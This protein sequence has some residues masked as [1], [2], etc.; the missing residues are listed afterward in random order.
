[1]TE[2]RA[3]S[4]SLVGY[5]EMICGDVEDREFASRPGGVNHPA[6]IL[7]HL[8]LTA[9]YTASIAGGKG[10]CPASWNSL[11][12]QKKPLSENRSEYPS[13]DELLKTLRAATENALN[14]VEKLSADK[15]DRPHEQGW[16]EKELPTMRDMLCFLLVGHAGIHVGQ[17][18][19]WRRM[20]GRA[21]L[22]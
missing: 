14:A 8:G 21:P 9:D 22:F 11:F 18:S 12:D 7:G 4:L 3:P 2:L 10:V 16:F 15:L 1:M 5:A 6:F 13:K 19:A 17:L 20:T